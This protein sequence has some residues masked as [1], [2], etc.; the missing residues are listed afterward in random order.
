MKKFFVLVAVLLV[1][2]AGYFMGMPM[3]KQAELDEL[4]REQL[5]RISSVQDYTPTALALKIHSSEGAERQQAEKEL[6]M[7]REGFLDEMIYRGA[8]LR[9]AIEESW[10]R[11]GVP[12]SVTYAQD[13]LLVAEH[14]D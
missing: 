8:S 10:A 3:M 13:S 5:V 7:A 1:L 4:S 6:L 12:K 14:V 2:G 11:F 9:C